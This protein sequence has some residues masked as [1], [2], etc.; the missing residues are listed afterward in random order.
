MQEVHKHTRDVNVG[1]LTRVNPTFP[2]NFATVLSLHAARLFSHPSSL[3]VK[4]SSS[5]CP[6]CQPQAVQLSSI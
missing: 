5:E 6:A 3:C 2:L 4:Y 1:A